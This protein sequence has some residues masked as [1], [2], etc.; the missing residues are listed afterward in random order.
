[1]TDSGDELPAMQPADPIRIGGL[2]LRI[3]DQLAA[4]WGVAPFPGGKTVWATVAPPA[5]RLVAPA[6]GAGYAA[7]VTGGRWAPAASCSSC[8]S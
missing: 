1:M 2:G 3:V 8:R 6:R 4:D 7:P 5:L